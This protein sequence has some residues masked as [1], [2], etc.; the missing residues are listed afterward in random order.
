M[1]HR[2]TVQDAEAL[3]LRALELRL[4]GFELLRDPETV[5]RECNGIGADWMPDSM[6]RLCTLLNPVME[7]PAAIHDRRYVLGTTRE[8]RAEADTEFLTNT[9]KVIRAQYAWYDPRRWLMC[10]RAFRYFTYLRMFGG[11]AWEA[12]K[13]Q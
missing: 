8:D 5:V 10:R 9:L 1:V 3:H 13:K 6:T 7:I 2:Y 12:A 11:A 4:S